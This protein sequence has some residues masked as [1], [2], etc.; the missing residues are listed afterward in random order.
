MVGAITLILRL[1][2]TPQQEIVTIHECDSC[3]RSHILIHFDNQ[4]PSHS[5][6]AI[7]T[8]DGRNIRKAQVLHSAVSIDGEGSDPYAEFEIRDVCNSGSPHWFN[9]VCAAHRYIARLKRKA[10]QTTDDRTTAIPGH[11]CTDLSSTPPHVNTDVRVSNCSQQHQDEH[12]DCNSHGA[13]SL[14]T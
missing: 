7:Q 3:L 13:F 1:R 12:M 6:V 4:K 10:S 9:C 5:S 2:K 14:R 8:R 11:A